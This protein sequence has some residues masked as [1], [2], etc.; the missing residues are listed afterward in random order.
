MV[1]LSKSTGCRSPII[2]NNVPVDAVER[3]SANQRAAD[4]PLGTLRARYAHFNGGSRVL[5]L[6]QA[7]PQSSPLQAHPQAAPRV[8]CPH[9][10]D[11]HIL[12]SAGAHFLE[13]AASIPRSL[14]DGLACG[15][16][17]ALVLLGHPIDSQRTFRIPSALLSFTGSARFSSFEVSRILRRKIIYLVTMYVWLLPTGLIIASVFWAFWIVFMERTAISGRQGSVRGT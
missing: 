9:C 11:C 15:H 4:I 8:D 13:S 17:L 5:L 2:F 10:G 7:P 12:P 6:T 16:R 3:L 1:R 14:H